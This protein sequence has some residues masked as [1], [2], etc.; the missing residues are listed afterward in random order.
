M[1]AITPPLLDAQRC[2][3]SL[4]TAELFFICSLRLLVRAARQGTAR[5][6]AYDRGFDA[7]KLTSF[8]SDALQAA[9]DIISVSALR[10]IEVGCLQRV[11]VS[12]DEERFLSLMRALQCEDEFTTR[13]ILKVWLPTAA[14]RITALHLE[15]LAT[16][17]ACVGLLFPRITSIEYNCPMLSLAVRRLAELE[18]KFLH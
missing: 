7:G 9:F 3:T 6:P 4:R 1:N 13:R 8:H 2:L 15:G 17:M 16:G 5:D 18:P 10:P 11:D 12:A 14:A